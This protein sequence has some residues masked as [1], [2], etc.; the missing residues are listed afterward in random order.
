MRREWA[1][2]LKKEGFTIL[3]TISLKNHPKLLVGKGTVSFQITVPSSPGE[4]R[5]IKNFVA[6]LRRKYR[7]EMGNVEDVPQ[8]ETLRSLK[9]DE[10]V[11]LRNILKRIRKGE[12][13]VSNTT[14]AG[15]GYFLSENGR[16]SAA[17]RISAVL[18][19]H[20]IQED[21]VMADHS[22]F[23]D[24]TCYA[25]TPMG[26][27]KADILIQQEEAKPAVLEPP[28]TPAR[29]ESYG[30]RKVGILKALNALSLDTIE[31]ALARGLIEIANDVDKQI[32]N[33]SKKREGITSA[34]DNLGIL[35]YS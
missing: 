2:A 24:R 9:D 29:E 16:I 17:Y 15:T 22:L 20:L 26:L 18:G 12:L 11:Q 1:E 8:E 32:N 19:K 7:A 28:L 3:E 27:E 35:Q 34:L 23:A 5:G 10:L 30:E 21:L 14:K 6:M 13:L 33:L 31:E 25:L 4:Y